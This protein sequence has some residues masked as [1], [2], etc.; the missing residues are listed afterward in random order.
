M[1]VF[2]LLFKP[3]EPRRKETPCNREMTLPLGRSVWM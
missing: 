2:N 1:K 3:F